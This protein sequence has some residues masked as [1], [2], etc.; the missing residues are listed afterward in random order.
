MAVAR[1]IAVGSAVAALSDGGP[2]DAAKARTI[3][4]L[5]LRDPR[6]LRDLRRAPEAM[7]TMLPRNWAWL[8][9]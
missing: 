7:P 8:D 3:E 4:V 1:T 6:E 9:A 2:N 5:I